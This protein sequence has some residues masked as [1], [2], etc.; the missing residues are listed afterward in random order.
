M[1]NKNNN[2]NGLV[3][4]APSK[5]ARARRNKILSALDA[6]TLAIPRGTFAT[7]GTAAGGAMYG[8]PGAVV[9]NLLGKTLARVT[10]RGDYTV[11]ANSI[12]MVGGAVD[13]IPTFSHHGQNVRIRHRE[14]VRDFVVPDDPTTFHNVA[15]KLNPGNYE[16]FP[17]LSS[18]A[19]QYQQYRPLG[20]IVEFASRSSDYASSGPL[21][22]IGI[23]TNYNVNDLPY[24]THSQFE[25]SEFAVSCKPSRSIMHAIECAPSRGRDEFLYV[26]DT[27]M[28]DPSATNDDRFSDI[29]SLQIMSV[30]LPSTPG[31]VLGQIWITYDIE[32]VKP[33]V[34][35]TAPVIPLSNIMSVT[36]RP[37]GLSTGGAIAGTIVS[38]YSSPARSLSA[39]TIYANIVPNAM[40]HV[41]GLPLSNPVYGW[42]F[43]DYFNLRKI[44][45]YKITFINIADT[46]SVNYVVSGL[47]ATCFLPELDPR[48]SVPEG[49]V[50]NFSHQGYTAHCHN[51][52]L[53]VAGYDNARV[54]TVDVLD[55]TGGDIILHVPKF[56]TSGSN[57]VS[58]LQSKLIIEWTAMKLTMGLPV[59]T[60]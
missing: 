10:G 13:E 47:D 6:A 27:A 19:R 48:V 42:Y 55:L 41:S 23:A 38:E 35:P 7:M 28:T 53:E 2:N 51:N 56:K 15:Y 16:L 60:D 52:G 31:L 57:L 45:R 32:F 59:S 30:G 20:M 37:D 21:G 50:A 18:V 12:S 33:I 58:S 54:V 4:A 46:T 1:N 49:S 26:R 24:S 36:S 14:F 39:S 8:P 29:G 22:T 25:N 11:K 3:K 5:R 34:S 17:W 9:G 43:T 40:T 44:G